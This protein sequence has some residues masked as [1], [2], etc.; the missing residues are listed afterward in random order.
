MTADRDTASRGAGGAVGSMLAVA[1]TLAA[2]VGLLTAGHALLALEEVELEEVAPELE[3]A[4]KE[5]FADATEF[6]AFE[7]DDRMVYRAIENGDHIGSAAIAEGEGYGGPIETLIGVDTEGSV[8]GVKVLDHDETPD[9]GDV[10]AEDEF[11][12]R[13]HG[14]SE[15]DPVRIDEDIDNITGATESA[16]AVAEAVRAALAHL[17]DAENG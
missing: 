7:H 13:F 12:S 16:E 4:L 10:V 9:L 6:T 5:V 2:C 8:V 17:A 1:I 3:D 15:A 11:L 14:K